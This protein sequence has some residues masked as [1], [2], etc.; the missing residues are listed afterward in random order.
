MPFGKKFVVIKNMNLETKINQK[1]AWEVMAV[2]SVGAAGLLI[3]QHVDTLKEIDDL[4]KNQ[5]LII[6]GS[7]RNV[8][9]NVLLRI[10]FPDKTVK[11]NIDISN[12]STA[13]SLLESIAQKENFKIE[14]KVYKDMG[15][16]VESVNG[17]KNGADNKYWQY[18]V[19][20][21]LPMIAADKNEVK[22]G[23]VIEWKFG[24][25]SF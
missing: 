15:V 24:K 4:V 25:M 18:W 5:N 20:G 1:L 2:L 17:F 14:S 12:S 22:E 3:T 10:Y 23:D 21:K 6:T 9:Q 16:L 7:I 11:Y 8:E 13:F 19:N